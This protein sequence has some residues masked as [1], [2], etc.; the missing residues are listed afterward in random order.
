MLAS[1]LA[2]IIIIISVGVIVLLDS[3]VS[4]VLPIKL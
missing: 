3:A 1:I 4:H 2:V